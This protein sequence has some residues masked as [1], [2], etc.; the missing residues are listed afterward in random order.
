MPLECKFSCDCGCQTEKKDSNHWFV[1]YLADYPR[2][3]NVYPWDEHLARNEGYL[4]AAGENCVHKLLG[5]WF[6]PS[7]DQAIETYV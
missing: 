7:Y 5:K 1:V 2:A 4:V 3:F 6:R